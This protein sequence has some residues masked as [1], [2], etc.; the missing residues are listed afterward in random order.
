M[1]ITGVF[2]SLK[3]A[4]DTLESLSLVVPELPKFTVTITDDALAKRKDAIELAQD[5]VQVTT[6]TERDDAL[7][8][9][10]LIKGLE[11]QMEETYEIVKKPVRVAGQAIDKAKREYLEG[12]Q[13]ERARIERMANE[14]QQAANRRAEA[15]RQEELREMQAQAAQGI[16]E[17]EMRQQAARA[18]ELNQKPQV[19]GTMMREFLDYDILDLDALYAHA[20]HLNLDLVKLEPSRSAILAY[21]NTPGFVSAPGLATRLATKLHAKASV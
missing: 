14:F 19:A 7:A 12:L 11:K 4:S 6:I 1:N 13:A 8:A 10:S 21:I 9:A 5:I 3:Q 17:D 15:L 2:P 16:S 20:K 18:A